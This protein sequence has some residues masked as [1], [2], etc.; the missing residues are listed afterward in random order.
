MSQ[1][2][3]LPTNICLY[4]TGTSRTLELPKLQ[5]YLARWLPKTWIEIREGFVRHWLSR[6]PDLMRA[7]KTDE[8]A[9]RFAR[10]KVRDPNERPG[11][12]RPLY[13]EIEYERRRLNDPSM[14]GFGILYDGVGLLM[15]YSDLLPDEEA[16]VDHLHVVFTDQLFGTWDPDDLRYH[17]RVN[18]CGYP[19][20]IST[21]GIIEGPAK[22]REY[23]LL[24]RSYEAMGISSSL[25]ME[26]KE[27]FRGRFID[28][29]DARLTDAMKGY[30]MQCLFFHTT[31]QPFCDDPECRLYNA[32][33]QEELIRAQFGEVEFC[34]KHRE[35]LE[36]MA[37]TF[38]HGDT[39][40]TEMQGECEVS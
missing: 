12:F 22:P 4:Y 36:R 39:E 32:H 29:D 27:R 34:E 16:R 25:A 23:Y 31:G 9:E 24:K 6:I 38:N 11:T 21:T 30:V 8:V 14:R 35:I 2:L 37:R 28:Y 3:L 15:A 7:A 26:L 20:M 40:N 18:L 13:G 5:T 17:V 1:K 19:S 10:I 33:W